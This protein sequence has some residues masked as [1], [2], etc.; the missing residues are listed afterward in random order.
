MNYCSSCGGKLIAHQENVSDKSF[1][2]YV[3]STC[4]AVHQHHPKIL[5]ACFIRCGNKMLW[6][7]RA[8]PPREGY[9]ALPAGFME[10]GETLQ[11]AASRELFEETGVV[12]AAEKLQL[13]MLGSIGFINEVYV[14]FQAEVTSEF[15][16]SGDESLDVG[17]FSRE[18]LPWD[19]IAF[20]DANVYIEQAYDDIA[21]NHF[22]VYQAEITEENNYL[23]AIT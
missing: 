7:R 9:W 22:P 15:C 17:F 13:Y 6:M 5:A 20:P 14:A 10:Q 23:L 21:A 19:D 18:E 4:G 1:T 16:E 3:C 11:E 8:H 2:Y 12:I